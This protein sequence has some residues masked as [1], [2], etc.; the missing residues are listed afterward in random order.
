[1]NET[2]NHVYERLSADEVAAVNRLCDR[3]EQAWRDGT[4]PS[5]DSFLG[6]STAAIRKVLLHEL[7]A[8]D[9][10]YRQQE[11]HAFEP[12]RAYQRFTQLDKAWL[13]KNVSSAIFGTKPPSVVGTRIGGY[14]IVRKLASGGMG[15]V[16]LAQQDE[17]HRLVALKMMRFGPS[18]REL[19]RRFQ[20]E[21]QVLARLQHPNIAQIYEV[22]VTDSGADSKLPWF[23]MEYVEGAEPITKFARERELGV[24]DRLRLF[25]PVCEAVGHG[26]QRGIIHRDLKPGN[27]LVNTEGRVQI[28]D[29]GVARATHGDIAMTMM[30]TD[31][32][33]LVGTLQY[34]SPEQ[35][36][37]DP[38]DL[39]ARSD[40]YSMGVVLYELLC[41]C[42]PYEVGSR[43]VLDAARVIFEDTPPP[44]SNHNRLLRD[45]IGTIVMTALHKDREQRYQSTA[46]LRRDIERF[47]DHRPI[48]ARPPT[49]WYRTKMLVGRHWAI[50][51]AI[52]TTLLALVATTI[53]SLVFAIRASEARHDANLDRARKSRQAYIASLAAA[54]SGRFS[55]EYRAMPD[56]LNSAPVEHRGWEWDVLSST[57]EASLSV[58]E[59]PEWVTA[60]ATRDDGTVACGRRDGRIRVWHQAQQEDFREQLAHEGALLSVAFD[61]IRGRLMTAARDRRIRFWEPQT[62]EPLGELPPGSDSG[63][64]RMALFASDYSKI[65]SIE[66]EDDGQL[67]CWDATTHEPLHQVVIP[68]SPAWNLA[69]SPDGRLIATGQLDGTVCVWDAATLEHRHRLKKLGLR[70]HSLHFTADGSRLCSGHTGHVQVWDPI[71]GR[72]LDTLKQQGRALAI[73]TADDPST[74]VVGW[75]AVIRAWNLN[76]GREI[77]TLVGHQSEV[78]ALATCPDRGCLVSGSVDRTVQTWD[79]RP[80]D[81]LDEYSGHAGQVFDISFSTDGTLLGTL[82]PDQS[83]RIWDARSHDLLANIPLHHW[84]KS[85]DFSPDGNSVAHSSR[86]GICIRDVATGRIVDQQNSALVHSVCFDPTGRYLA[87]GTHDAMVHLYDVTARAVRWRREGH[88][89]RVTHVAIDPTGTLV[90]SGSFD[91][92]IRLWDLGTGEPRGQLS[93]NHTATTALAYH[94]DGSLLAAAGDDQR[95]RIWNVET[96]VLEQTL[97]A[98]GGAIVDLAF[99]P[100]GSRLA[101]SR[102]FEGLALWDT[103]DWKMV[104]TLR[105]DRGRTPGVIAFDRS[106]DRFVIGCVEGAIELWD[107]RGSGVRRNERHVALAELDN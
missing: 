24:S 107:R 46:D 89:D 57:S 69:I 51:V 26:H 75:G 62:L 40:V 61:P 5:I 34:M 66:A 4:R 73:A 55:N 27:I 79:I 101:S 6:M 105:V 7:V 35:C 63:F 95:V 8:I 70:I 56:H 88:T 103:S 3:F 78:S 90:A 11:D 20:Y 52:T 13:E 97:P 99:H 47:L 42:L 86:D 21:S 18:S 45:D 12:L 48:E 32:G 58:L 53:V 41:D 94:P 77:R 76:D 22:G 83:L 16:Y 9:A 84:A 100:D 72:W 2:S 15:T 92:S 29:F 82:A 81:N 93:D 54:E 10:A 14:K 50:S 64:F 19:L 38:A 91:H 37:A 98:H 30:Q 59:Q 106:G 104:L 67:V 102:W 43:P 60:I 23:A 74:I 1:M 44:P 36:R 85:L 17:P 31:V 68:G 65:I 96:M 33:Q 71:E 39:D 80:L 49:L 25:L 87:Y 28:I